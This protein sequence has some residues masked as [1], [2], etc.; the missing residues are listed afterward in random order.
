MD[1]T[2]GVD[3]ALISAGLV[4]FAVRSRLPFTHSRPSRTMLAVTGVVALVALVIPYPP[5]AGLL[6]SQAMTLPS[7]A[8][9]AAIV[10]A[11][12]ASAEL[13]KRLFYRRN[14]GRP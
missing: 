11:Y 12:F 14:G 6:G 10:A 3:V 4:V 2:A 5:I 8:A 9:V 13:T 7:L 1:A